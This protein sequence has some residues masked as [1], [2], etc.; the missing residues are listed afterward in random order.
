MVSGIGQ[1]NWVA[2]RLCVVLGQVARTLWFTALFGTPWARAYGVATREEH[3]RAIPP[4]TYG[5]GVVCTLLVTVGIAS[6]RN[7]LGVV[8]LAA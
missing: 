6:L 2:I 4:W 1:L 7:I 5:V 8:G 3:A